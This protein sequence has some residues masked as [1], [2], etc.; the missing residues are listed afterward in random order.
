M[1]YRQQAAMAAIIYTI[2]NNRFFNSHNLG[3]K[4]IPDGARMYNFSGQITKDSINFRDD[5][6][7]RISDSQY[8]QNPWGVELD[9]ISSR[10]SDRLK[11]YLPENSSSFYGKDGDYFRFD[12]NYYSPSTEVSIRDTSQDR[13]E[14][15]YRITW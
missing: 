15:V 9:Y 1:T 6:N 7:N 12:G 13:Y 3:V 8:Y 11:L 5:K 2:K 14:S 4:L 10:R